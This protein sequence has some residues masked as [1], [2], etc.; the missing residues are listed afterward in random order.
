MYASE[1]DRISQRVCVTEKPMHHKNLRHSFMYHGYMHLKD[2]CGTHTCRRYEGQSQA[3]LKGPKL[4]K[5]DK[6]LEVSVQRG[7]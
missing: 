1:K 5:E 2:L 7:P 6:K 4:A 3:C